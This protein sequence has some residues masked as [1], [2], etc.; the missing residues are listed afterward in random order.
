[1][2]NAM[3]GEIALEAGG[4]MYTL[5]VGMNTLV[6]LEQLF[7]TAER[8]MTYQEVIALANRNSFTHIRGLLW[9]MLRKHH[10]EMTPDQVGDLID[11]VGLF[12]ID[13]RLQDAVREMVPD[14]ADLKALGIAPNP[15]PAQASTKAATGKRST[16]KRAAS[17]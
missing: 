14:A 1:M 13:Q 6:A 17:A 15:R 5:A 7:S 9:A 10:R 3:N 12:A 4:K 8:R 11:E 2:A 16:R